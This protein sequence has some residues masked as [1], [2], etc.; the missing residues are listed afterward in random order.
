[1]S[2]LMQRKQKKKQIADMWRK[3]GMVR[4]HV[5]ETNE[6]WLLPRAKNVW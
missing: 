3:E 6:I 5:P 2:Q 4:R 1:M